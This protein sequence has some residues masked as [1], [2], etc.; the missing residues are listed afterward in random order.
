MAVPLVRLPHVAGQP[1][2]R[3]PRV[4]AVPSV[5]GMA[6]VCAKAMLQPFDTLK[7][8]QQASAASGSLPSVCT[9]LVRTNGVLALYRGLGISLFGAV[10]AMSAY[11]AVY[12]SL[13][14]T[15][16]SSACAP[17]VLL[18]AVSAAMANTVSAALRVPCELIK[19]RIQAGM[20]PSV[21]TAIRSIA[22]GVARS[23][24]TPSPT[25]APPP[26]SPPFRSTAPTPR[27]YTLWLRRRRLGL[28]ATRRA[29]RPTG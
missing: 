20:Y 7:T 11:F 13:K 21:G 4:L 25:S 26:P 12:Q 16:I 17:P 1:P 29:A 19:Q 8:L 5:A 24:P 9:E 6:T 27:R 10:P 15:L 28:P 23:P 18:V 14:N 3:V 22:A 2:P